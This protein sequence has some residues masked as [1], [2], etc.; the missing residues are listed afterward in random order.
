M[1]SDEQV[2][3]ALKPC[4]HCGSKA[5]LRDSAAGRSRIECDECQIGQLH[6]AD[7]GEALASWNRRAALEAALS[8]PVEGWR[9]QAKH[10]EGCEHSR[11]PVWI[12]KCPRPDVVDRQALAAAHEAYDGS[13]D[14]QPREHGQALY[15]AIAACVAAIPAGPAGGES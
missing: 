9:A 13:H 5:W 1:V 7:H 15:E 6:F 14:A 4:P 3:A 10:L 2:E 8:P 11:C 12:C